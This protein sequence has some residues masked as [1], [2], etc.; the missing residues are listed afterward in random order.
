MRSSA[1]LIIFGRL[2]NAHPIKSVPRK[3]IILPK[4]PLVLLTTA[5]LV[6]LTTP[7][8]PEASSKSSLSFLFVASALRLASILERDIVLF[9]FIILSSTI[10]PRV[11]DDSR[12]LDA[13]DLRPVN[14]FVMF[15]RIGEFIRQR[16]TEVEN[17]T[18]GSSKSSHLEQMGC[19][20][21][22]RYHQQLLVEQQKYR[23]YYC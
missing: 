21:H 22:C 17:I 19:C 5:F 16:Y 4:K 23:C 3:S 6:C 13:I 12:V 9:F 8:I 18:N 7:R 20:S 11:F 1:N 15:D 2:I 10:L 14:V